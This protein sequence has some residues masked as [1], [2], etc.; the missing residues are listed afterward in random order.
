MHRPACVLVAVATALA[1]AVANVRSSSAADA[2]PI[3]VIPGRLG[4][5][6]IIDGVSFPELEV[7]FAW[8]DAH[9]AIA[10]A[11]TRIDYLNRRSVTPEKRK[12]AHV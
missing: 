9:A 4:M 10:D 2:G 1:A 11:K 5:P 6:V 12:V 7:G 8:S 3:I